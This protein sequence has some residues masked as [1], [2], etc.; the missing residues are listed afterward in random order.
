MLKCLLGLALRMDPLFI[1][2]LGFKQKKCVKCGAL[3][4]LVGAFET[5]LTEPV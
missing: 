3:M 4:V 1:F 5:P 2:T